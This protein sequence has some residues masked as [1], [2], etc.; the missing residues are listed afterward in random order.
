MPDRLRRPA[1]GAGAHRTSRPGERSALR[2]LLSL[3]MPIVLVQVGLMAMGVVD[4]IMVGHVSATALSAVALGNVYFFALAVFGMGMLMA[5]DPIVAQAVGAGDEPAVARAVQRGLLIAVAVSLVTSALLLP[6]EPVLRTL[7]QPPEVVPLAASYAVVSIPGTLPFFA[8]IVLRQTLQA[9]GHV[10]PILMSIL[11]ANVV[12]GLLNWM[13]IFGRLGL[14]ALGAIGSAWATSVSRLLLVVLLGVAGWRQLRHR[15]FPLRREALSRRPLVRMLA[16]GAPI[17][18]QHQLE[19]G[20][21]GV[22]ALLMGW[23]GARQMAGHQIAIN[24]ASITFMVPLGVSGAAAVLVGRAVGRGDPVALRRASSAALVSGA[25]FMM[26]SAAAFLAAP[27][28]LARVYSSDP[29]VVAIAALLIPIAGVF[30][31]FDGLQVVATGVLRGLGDTRAPM[32]VAI[33]G[34]WLLGMPVSL[35]LGFRAGAGP[36]GLWW[37]L[38]VGLGA[39]ALFLMARVHLRLGRALERVIIDDAGSTEREHVVSS[40]AS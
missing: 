37:G 28:Y 25:A 23:M 18:V 10:R 5:L 34:F 24:L 26:V 12:N 35:F 11:A 15:V 38:V 39:V 22:V 33:L 31:V 36:A 3:A 13:L 6:A 8:F 32:V 14:P 30:Q 2:E 9:T 20:A 21:F 4:T 1:R 29:E 19:Y 16:L 40:A 17:G 7:G 27:R